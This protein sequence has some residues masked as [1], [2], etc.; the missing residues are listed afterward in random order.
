VHAASAVKRSR[1][2]LARPTPGGRGA[3]GHLPQRYRWVVEKVQ[4]FAERAKLARRV[5]DAQMES[6]A[7][8]KSHPELISTYLS[9]RSAQE[10]ARRRIAD[11]K[12]RERFLSLVREAMAR[13]VKAGEPLPEVRIR[14]QQ[15][16]REAI[17]APAKM[18][19]GHEPVR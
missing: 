19:R 13:S 10:V 8:M 12:D 2:G 16:H 3:S 5:R 15:N 11:P 14:E 7:A 6:R 17:R 18:T 9:L 4:F 1:S